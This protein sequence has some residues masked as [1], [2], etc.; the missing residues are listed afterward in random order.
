MSKF[1]D[2]VPNHND[3]LEFLPLFHTCDSFQART[4]IGKKLLRTEDVCEIF[5][6]PITYLFYGRPAFK[7]TVRDGNTVNLA[8]YPICFV[9]DIDLIGAIRRIY[10]FD[11]GALYHKILERFIHDK[12]VVADFELEPSTKRI[13]DVILQFHGSNRNYIESRLRD[14]LAIDPFNFESVSFEKMHDRYAPDR[15]DERRVTI[16]IQAEQELSLTSGALKAIIVPTQM[17]GSPFLLNFV[18]TVGCDVRSYDIDV[19]DPKSSFAL[20][21]SEAKKYIFSLMKAA[22][23][24]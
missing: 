19:W 23:M 22:T 2:Q 15:S 7:Y 9:F 18:S 24:V 12:N 6:E 17:L 21:A 3:V 11:T 16:E 4:Y 5:K 20:V 8:M 10:P 14:K 1:S 13:S